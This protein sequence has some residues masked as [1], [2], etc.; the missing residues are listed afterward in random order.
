MS[1]ATNG[2]LTNP[3]A[4][5]AATINGVK[6]KAA[7][8]E[9][10]PLL[11]PQLSE[12]GANYHSSSSSSTTD[13]FDLILSTPS[14]RNGQY[15]NANADR[16]AGGQLNAKGNNKRSVN[17][18]LDDDVKHQNTMSPSSSPVGDSSS[19]P[20]LIDDKTMVALSLDLLNDL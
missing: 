1:D 12:N 9:M 15:D 19:S 16:V 18:S 7:H 13:L 2:L 11:L 20:P 17:E 14:T 5:A 6:T 10:P 4:A 8:K 3:M